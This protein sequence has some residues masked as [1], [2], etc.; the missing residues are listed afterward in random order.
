MRQ[1]IAV[2]IVLMIPAFM[3]CNN[4]TSLREK[5]AQQ[6]EQ[7]FGA[8]ARQDADEELLSALAENYVKYADKN[9]RDSLSSEYLFKAADIYMNM[10]NGEEAMKQLDKILK[11]YPDFEK[12][13]EVTFLKAYIYENYQG[14]LAKAKEFYRSFLKKYPGHEFA[15]DVEMSLK[16]LGKSPEELVKQFEKENA[17]GSN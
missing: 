4:E 17:A 12:R 7:L 3:A 11:S 16:H 2:T 8:D 15:D 1:L 6:E 5:I 9:P 13:A 10:E 14:K